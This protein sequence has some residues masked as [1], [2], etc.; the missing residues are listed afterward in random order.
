MSAFGRS[1]GVLILG[2]GLACAM[3][4]EPLLQRQNFWCRKPAL[5]TT[6][7]PRLTPFRD[8]GHWVIMFSHQDLSFTFLPGGIAL[9]LLTTQL[10]DLDHST[11]EF[12]EITR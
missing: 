9:V 11:N 10:G 2:R 8:L 6:A 7:T 12:N 1:L 5:P 4:G 3:A